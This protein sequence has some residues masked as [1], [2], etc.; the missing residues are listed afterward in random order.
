MGK[1]WGIII[2]MAADNDLTPASINA[3]SRIRETYEN[4]DGLKDAVE[5]FVYFDGN[6]YG[7]PS[8][9]FSFSEHYR[10]VANAGISTAQADDSFK[11]KKEHRR[12]YRTSPGSIYNFVKSCSKVESFHDIE[13]FVLILSC[14]GFGFQEES[15]MQDEGSKFSATV[16]ELA[17]KLGGMN[18]KFFKGKLKL[19]GF[20][21]CVM[22]SLE[23]AYEIASEQ[24]NRMGF[25]DEKL[26]DLFLVSS[27]GYVP[28][29]GWNY[30][31]VLKKIA[32]EDISNLDSRK[33]AELFVDSYC[34]EYQPH[35]DYAGKSI[36]ISAVSLGVAAQVKEHIFSIGDYLREELSNANAELFLKLSRIILASHSQCQ[37]FLYDQC[38]D[39]KDFF[40]ILRENLQ[41]EGLLSDQIKNSFTTIANS[42]TSE[43]SYCRTLGL[44][45]NYAG[46]MTLY[47]PWS[48]DSFV[49][50]MAKYR[51]LK[52]GH[53]EDDKLDG[54]G[55]FMWEY[56]FKNAR[57]LEVILQSGDVLELFIQLGVI[58]PEEWNKEFGNVFSTGGPKGVGGNKV[59]PPADSKV[60]PPADSKVNPPADSKMKSQYIENFRRTQNIFWLP[61]NARLRLLNLRKLKKS[62]EIAIAFN[63]TK[64]AIV[65]AFVD[66]ENDAPLVIDGKY[67]NKLLEDVTNKVMESIQQESEQ[68]SS[69]GNGSETREESESLKRLLERMELVS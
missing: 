64:D 14:H 25:D 21:S 55:L 4:N 57:G 36:D 45:T 37:L 69:N 31:R 15:L 53:S 27:E 66:S 28:L 16:K 24:K 65:N 8:Y 1:K 42:F 59:N 61:A 49:V 68:K 26:K 29:A 18:A 47:F 34:K 11:P 41:S 7:F 63:V 10:S 52:F 3:L 33:M 2:Y 6:A 56:L 13:N 46:G 40:E 39:I 23:V 51:A 44:E 43:T 50:V 58:V 17:E 30:A 12:E 35:H 9:E 32:H 62:E 22:N 48:F 19:I 54:W 5:L 20:D 67:V 38:V 60:N